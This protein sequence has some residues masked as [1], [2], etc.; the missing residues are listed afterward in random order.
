MPIL[1]ALPPTEADWINPDDVCR[2]VVTFGVAMA[3]VGR[4]ELDVH[5]HKKGQLMLSQRGALSCEVEGGLWIVPPGSAIWIPG[6]ALHA[7]KATGTLEGC[8][9]FVDADAAA[10]L[11]K[12]CCT[13]SVTPLLRE[14]LIRSA[15]LPALYAEGSAESHLVTLLLDEIAA[16][17]IEDLHLPMPADPRLRKIA[18]MMI[19]DPAERGTMELWAGRAGMSERT[20]VRRLSEE[21]GMS[22]GRWR[23][24]LSV[25][26][27]VKGLSRGDSIQ[28]VAAGLGY[29]SVSSFVTMFRKALGT[30]PGRYR[31]EKCAGRRHPATPYPSPPENF[32][33]NLSEI[34]SQ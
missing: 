19:A 11:P 7:I 2:A 26:L 10:R 1:S 14:L 21:T 33:D 6:G 29:E 31:A 22:F 24:Q 34:F 9:A 28:Q 25:V 20:F 30:S 5:R 15:S 13:L 4:F 3:A 27:A 17:P 23:Q 8:N 18:N 12:A 32:A 16:A